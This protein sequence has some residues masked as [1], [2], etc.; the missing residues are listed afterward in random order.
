MR[1][2]KGMRP[3]DIV[4][5]LK[6]VTLENKQ[7]WYKKDL[8]A[9][10]HISNSEVSESLNRSV[11]A[12]L[13]ENDKETVRKE[14]LLE[15]LVYGVKYVFPAEPG[16]LLRGMA[17]AYSAPLLEKEFVI[18]NPHVWPAKGHSTKGIAINP[19]YQTVPQA[20]EKDP[21]LYEFLALTD[22]L[23][24]GERKS[25]VV[26]LL[27]KNLYGTSTSTPSIGE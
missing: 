17:T 23:R 4:I 14:P 7:N 27:A 18:D 9:Q 25:Q 5:L 22:A 13:I 16:T 11:V 3:Q 19:L 10:L 26:E 2:H 15:F 24:I 20:C 1:Q 21:K 6:I 12:G 8:A